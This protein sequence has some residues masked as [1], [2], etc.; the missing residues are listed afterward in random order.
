MTKKLLD[1]F[2][3]VCVYL[4]VLILVPLFLDYLFKMTIRARRKTNI[5]NMARKRA[6]DMHK[7]LVI[8]NST[9]DGI[10]E[11]ESLDQKSARTKESFEGNFDEIIGNM[12]DSCCVVVVS[13]VLE[14]VTDIKSTLTELQR[15]AGDDLYVIGIEKASPRVLWD[16]KLK[17]ILN[18][19]FYVPDTM[20]DG[21]VQSEIKW[22]A[23][24]QV[25]RFFQKFYSIIFK[26]VPY[27]FFASDPVE[28]V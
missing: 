14:Y 22:H 3:L 2:V 6:N 17:N 10:V 1:K 12:A 21:T 19:P 8:F 13:Q 27:K 7:S 26:I 11:H 20:S 23:P 18:K 25:Q 9:T 28:T 4:I 16:F 15:V 5:L 24:N